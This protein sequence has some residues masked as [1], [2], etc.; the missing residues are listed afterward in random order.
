MIINERVLVL[1]GGT[2]AAGVAYLYARLKRA[3]DKVA[4]SV[5]EMKAVGD[6]VGMSVEELAKKTTVDIE[7]AIVDRA[8]QQAVEREV[9]RHITVAADTAVRDVSQDMKAQIRTKV[10]SVYDNLETQVS[11]EL[12]RQIS[13]LDT[14]K[15]EADVIAKAEAS[16]AKKFDGQL[17]KV[18]DGFK[19]D[20]NNTSKIYGHIAS[21][22]IKDRTIPGFSIKL[23]N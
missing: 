3:E 18:L 9:G 17:D 6:K 2:V 4:K 10:T 16:V 1:V 13:E 5:E 22:L 15:L 8:V 20:L 7:T 11:D 19:H 14:K 12:A 21:S 23:G